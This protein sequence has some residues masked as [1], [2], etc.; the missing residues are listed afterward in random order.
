MTQEELDNLSPGELSALILENEKK[1][2]FL[3][4]Q[5]EGL[6]ISTAH[7]LES[8]PSVREA[9]RALAWSR[10]GHTGATYADDKAAGCPTGWP[11]GV[12]AKAFTAAQIERV[13]GE[14]RAKFAVPSEERPPPVTA[15]ANVERLRRML[16]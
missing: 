11:A 6:H 8:D 12:D 4:G 13:V 3:R 15:N 10:A 2:A 7:Q 5:V 16:K 9:F 14:Q 1:L